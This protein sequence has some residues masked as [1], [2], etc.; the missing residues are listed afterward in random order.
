[1]IKGTTRLAAVIGWPIDHTRSPQMLNAAF[2]SAGLDAVMIPVGVPPA[3]LATVVAGLRASR[4]LGA[5]VT[6]P[7]KLAALA[8]CDELS[9]AA[10]EIGAVNCL[11]FADER[12]VGHNTD[13]DGFVD[14]LVGAGFDRSSPR[15][16]VLLGGGGAARGVA[17]GL[18]GHNIASDLQVIA[19]R[20]EAVTWTPAVAWTKAALID[21]FARADLVV[22]C[23]TIGLGGSDEATQVDALPVDALRPHAWT[24]TLV[25]HRPTIWLER[26]RA[27]G[28]STLDGRAMLVHQGA[29]AF[30]IW[31]GRPAPID[32]MAR[33]L[34]DSLRGT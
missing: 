4:A 2:A 10:R 11:H 9:P 15:H 14:A 29:R 3:Q 32:A 7:H 8:L 31:T 33:A 24:A 21:A 20:P 28:H 23:T 5:S 27:R 26:T 19:R 6:V 25:Y 18:R 12:I 30:S 22:D 16:V 17:S 13:A 34:D 1:M